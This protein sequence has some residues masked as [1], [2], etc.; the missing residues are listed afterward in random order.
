MIDTFLMA[1]SGF[2]SD[3]LSGLHPDFV[4]PE[5]YIILEALLKTHITKLGIRVNT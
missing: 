4:G 2:L 3:S 1:L 5:A